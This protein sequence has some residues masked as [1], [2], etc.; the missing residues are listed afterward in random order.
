MPHWLACGYAPT[1]Q[2]CSPLPPTHKPHTAHPSLA[3]LQVQH[4]RFES[5]TQRLHHRLIQLMYRSISE[6]RRGLGFRARGGSFG[7]GG[8]RE[9]C[10]TG[11]AAAPRDGRCSSL[12]A[13]SWRAAHGKKERNRVVAALPPAA[14]SPSPNPTLSPPTH[15]Q[16]HNHRQTVTRKRINYCRRSTIAR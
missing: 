4:V 9:T 13:T 7:G 6:G 16:E 14:P 15:Y 1:T 11:S 2:L 5:L 3:D 10:M 8:S 12:P